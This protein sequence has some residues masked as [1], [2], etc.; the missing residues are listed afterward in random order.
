[1]YPRVGV[2]VNRPGLFFAGI[3]RRKNLAAAAISLLALCRRFDDNNVD[4]A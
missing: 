3:G 1:M 2:H 4:C